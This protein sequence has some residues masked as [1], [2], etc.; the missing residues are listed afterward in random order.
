VAHEPHRIAYLYDLASEFT[1]MDKGRIL[2]FTLHYAMMQDYEGAP[3]VQASS[4]FWHRAL[5][6]ASTPTGC[7][8]QGEGFTNG[9]SW[10]IW[11]G[12]ARHGLFDMA[13]W[14]CPEG[15][16]SSRWLIDIRTDLFLRR[17]GSRRERSA[18]GTCKADRTNIQ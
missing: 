17:P 8:R 13:G 11:Q 15:D 4:R 9:G 6:S 5:F 2:L 18:C 7:G 3:G 1:R 10:G 14:R 16:A 12:H